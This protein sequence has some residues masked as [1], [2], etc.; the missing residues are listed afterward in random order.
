V[1]ATPLPNRP[2]SVLFSFPANIVGHAS[3]ATGAVSGNGWV[4]LEHCETWNHSAGGCIPFST[5][6]YKYPLPIC[7]LNFDGTPDDG[8]SRSGCDTYLISDNASLSELDAPALAPKFTWHGFQHV[9][10]TTSPGVTF[11]GELDAVSAHW[12]SSNLSKSASITFAG[13][14][15]AEILTS[16]D[17]IVVNSQI[18]NLAAFM[19]TDCPTR[20]MPM[21]CTHVLDLHARVC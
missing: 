20:K 3:L 16:L 18:S 2:N 9:V 8:S 17:Q 19:P 12:T 6:P 15:G 1:S 11:T 10:V 13:G 7:G 21:L 5:P 14:E 4:R